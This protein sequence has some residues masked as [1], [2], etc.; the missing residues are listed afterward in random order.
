VAEGIELIAVFLVLVGLGFLV[1]AGW[2]LR[3]AMMEEGRRRGGG[4]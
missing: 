3:Q 4:E 1:A 2:W